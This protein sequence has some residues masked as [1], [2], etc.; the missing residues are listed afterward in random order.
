[1]SL[2]ELIP[3]DG[4]LQPLIK[5][6][7]DLFQSFGV[8]ATIAFVISSLIIVVVLFVLYMKLIDGFGLNNEAKQYLFIVFVVGLAV[9]GLVPWWAIVILGLI[10]IV[11]VFFKILSKGVYE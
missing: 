1:M 11:I 8:P 7:S 9:I 3:K 10:G 5:A 4:I 2:T 6:F